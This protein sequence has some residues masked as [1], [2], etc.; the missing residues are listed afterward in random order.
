MCAK[1]RSIHIEALDNIIPTDLRA[2]A[3]SAQ[4]EGLDWECY[5]FECYEGNYESRWTVFIEKR[6]IAY[7]WKNGISEEMSGHNLPGIERYLLR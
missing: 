6:K 1:W 3:E 4:S 7:T 5:R 2:K